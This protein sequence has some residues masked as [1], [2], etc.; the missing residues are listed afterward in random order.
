MR[1]LLT[2]VCLLLIAG[3]ALAASM[4]AYALE[5]AERDTPH[6]IDRTLKAKDGMVRVFITLRDQ[7]ALAAMQRH[8][9]LQRKILGIGAKPVARPADGKAS[10]YISA[11]ERAVGAFRIEKRERA[12][13]QANRFLLAPLA[14]IKSLQ[15]EIE[16]VGGKLLEAH[17]APAGVLALLPSKA[18]DRIAHLQYVQAVQSQT[19]EKPLLDMSVP[20]TGA[21]TWWANGYKGGTGNPVNVCICAE[22]V[23][24]DHEWFISLTAV[25]PP[26]YEKYVEDYGVDTSHGTAV[27]SVIYSYSDDAIYKGVAFDMSK[28]NYGW[29]PQAY[30]GGISDYVWHL[31]GTQYCTNND[32]T[33]PGTE[34]PVEVQNFSAGSVPQTDTTPNS[35][36]AD[37][38]VYAFSYAL[39]IAAG[40]SP[41]ANKVNDP[42]IGYNTTC[43]GGID[44]MDTPDN[45]TDDVVYTDNSNG[46]TIG[47]RK[48]PD[49]SA[50]SGSGARLLWVADSQGG[51]TGEEGTSLAA[52]HVTGA[53]ALLISAGIPGLPVKAVLINSAS[54]ISGQDDGVWDAGAGWGELDLE[55]AF[56]WRQNWATSTVA[57]NK[58]KF[59][60]VSNVVA[61][62]KTTLT[63]YRRSYKPAQ[64]SLVTHTLTNLDLSLYDPGQNQLTA[65]SAS[66]IDNVELI[67]YSGANQATAYVKVDANST[68]EGISSEPFAVASSK[69]LTPVD[70]PTFDI[71]TSLSA[72]QAKQSDQVTVTSQI[73]NSGDLSAATATQVS[74]N[75][76]SEVDLIQGDQTQPVGTLNPNQTGTA[77]WT[78]QGAE[79]GLK[80]LSVTASATGW[81]ET[82]T[83]SEDTNLLI[84]STSPTS[85][86]GTLSQY[87]QSKTLPVSWSAMDTG[88][89]IASYEL[90]VRKGQL[91]WQSLGELPASQT[92]YTY[93]ADADIS[94]SFRVRAKDALGNVGEWTEGQTTTIDTKAP[95]LSLSPPAKK[96]YRYD[97]AKIGVNAK[98]SISGIAT[99]RYSIDNGPYKTFTA[100]SFT[101]QGTSGNY[102]ITVEAVDGAGNKGKAKTSLTFHNILLD[103]QLKIVKIWRKRKHVWL[104]GTIRPGALGNIK[105]IAKR[106][107]KG[108]FRAQGKPAKATNTNGAFKAKLKLKKKARY[109]FQATWPGNGSFLPGKASKEK[110]V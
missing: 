35:D 12:I 71:S 14:Q 26:G 30:C 9:A 49:I 42:C 39:A 17:A 4:P 95:T 20:S 37:Q 21:P 101:F 34:D 40:N 58:A 70:G 65:P 63:W 66:L 16:S 88:S 13:K 23:K 22:D 99:K 72:T 62:N 75:L 74:L 109:R 54:P 89:G 67:K 57:G 85:S 87:S 52:P 43:V 44:H 28:I 7:P 48:K 25:T 64:N 96:L 36:A 50:P 59:F 56:N 82:F 41:G 78:V 108:A 47:G 11:R 100:D 94:Y 76:P 90:E 55:R 80:Q 110:K 77:T 45:S 84:D 8:E 6:G 60:Q 93:T 105:L 2:V 81:D 107:K 10:P 86:M 38:T 27:A 68:V 61:G 51:K 102:S 32:N 3:L 79:D 83:F 5:R 69:P 24:P 104:K 15:A 33:L 46:P 53:Y 106:K 29:V 98:D 103:P 92:T 19:K 31:G 18:L 73:T 1:H 97:T 91:A